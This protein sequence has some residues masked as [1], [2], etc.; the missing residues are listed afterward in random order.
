MNK[1]D[2]KKNKIEERHDI[3]IG[4]NSSFSVTEA[5]NNLKTN[6]AFS[7]PEKEDGSARVIT[8]TS[9]MPTEG[10]TTIATNLAVTCAS[11]DS[12][13]LIIDG[14]M[15]CPRVNKLFKKKNGKGLSDYLCG[16]A[17]YEAVIKKTGITNLFAIFSGFNP[18]NPNQL[19]N[20]PKFKQLIEDMSKEYDYIII[21]TPPLDTMSDCLVVAPNTDGVIVV[22]KNK[23]STYPKVQ[24]VIEKLEFSKCKILGLV[25]NEYN[26]NSKASYYKGKYSYRYSSTN[27]YYG[28]KE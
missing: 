11:T 22:V 8:I 16:R 12:R 23:V 14:D 5:F 20:H 7:I 27:S 3:L 24:A 17:N 6:L 4:S 28:N 18:P 25:L 26:E 2:I 21:D 10:K 9:S 13:V 19:L 1:L 15:R